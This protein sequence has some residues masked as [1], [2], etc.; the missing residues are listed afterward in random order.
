[1]GK[2]GLL[3]FRV[4]SKLLTEILARKEGV[5]FHGLRCFLGEGRVGGGLM[6]SKEIYFFVCVK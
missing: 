1:M 4:G 2:M 3:L 5:D 6:C